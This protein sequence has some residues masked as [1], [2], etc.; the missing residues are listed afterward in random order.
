MS[1]AYGNMGWKQ[2]RYQIF[3]VP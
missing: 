1:V 3:R 2:W